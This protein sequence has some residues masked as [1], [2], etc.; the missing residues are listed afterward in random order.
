MQIFRLATGCM[1]IIKFLMSLFKPP[2]NF[3]LNIESP[4]SVMTH[5][6]SIIFYLKH[7]TLCSKGAH[8]SAIFWDLSIESKFA[9]F[10]MSSFKAQ[11]SSSSNF[12]SFFTVM[13][14]NS[15]VIFWLKYNIL[16]TKISD[17]SAN[18]QAC[19]CSH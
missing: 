6:S 2:L 3:S 12:A 1:K 17:R 10:L 4:F 13:T 14:H 7:Y 8:Q 15:F 9:K 19:H 18:P 11:V 16:S 5:N